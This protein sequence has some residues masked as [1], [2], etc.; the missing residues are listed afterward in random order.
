MGIYFY[1]KGQEPKYVLRTFGIFDFTIAIPPGEEYHPEIASV[2]FPKDAMLYGITPHA[3]TRGGSANVSIRYPD[4]REEMLIALPRYD[5]SWQYEYFLAKPTKIPAGATIIARW[6]YDNSKRNPDNPDYK[7]L[8]NWG[9]QTTEE[10]LATYLHYRWV[11]ETVA[12]QTPEYEKMLQGNLMLGVMD[13]N[14]DGKLQPAELRGQ[15]GEGILKYLPIVDTNKDGA[16]DQKELDAAMKLL[17]RGR[18]G[19]G[20]PPPPMPTKTTDAA[21]ATTPAGGR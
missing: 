3:H 13:D 18:R 21:P 6:T 10:M 11:D 5:F 2:T 19:G 15:M 7:K 4:G 8:V 1:P 17:P 20:G 16:I 12:H 9:E 14:L